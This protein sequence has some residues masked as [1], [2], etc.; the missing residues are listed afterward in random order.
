M[1][2]QMPRFDALAVGDRA[3]TTRC[4][5]A[6]D[7]AQWCD[8]MSLDQAPAQ[9]P[10]PL[11]AA[12]F[13]YLLGEQLPGHGTNYLKQDMQFEDMGRIGETLTVEVRISRLRR[14]KALV[15]LDTTC[16]GSDGR[17]ICAGRALVLFAC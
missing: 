7:M 6:T 15:D 10:E 9:V 1:S 5:S 14:D 12:L 2:E 13:S 3:T 8:M 11:V 4:F 17:T 16:T